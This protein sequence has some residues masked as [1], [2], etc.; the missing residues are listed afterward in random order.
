MT[1]PGLG[2]L[3][4]RQKF[5]SAS[6]R[7]QSYILPKDWYMLSFL[8]MH[9]VYGFTYLPQNDMHTPKCATKTAV[10][11]IGPYQLPCLLG[12]G[13]AESDKEGIQ[14]TNQRP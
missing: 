10:P 8:G 9:S 13:C 11:G 2:L 4:G 14:T 5:V 12:G 1:R 6:Q 3:S 7:A